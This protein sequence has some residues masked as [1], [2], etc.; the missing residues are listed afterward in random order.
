MSKRKNNKIMLPLLVAWFIFLIMISIFFMFFFG[1]LAKDEKKGDDRETKFSY[2]TNADIEINAT[3]GDYFT[4]LNACD[5]EWLK[6]MVTDPSQ[7]DDMSYYEMLSQLVK[8][9]YNINCYSVDGLNENEVLVF[10]T[11]NLEIDGLDTKPMDIQ[12]FYMIKNADGTYTINNSPSDEINDYIFK[13][14]SDEDIQEIYKSVRDNV[15]KCKED[16]PE[17]AA[18][19]NKLF[20]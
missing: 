2:R 13:V 10:V 11:Y 16:D 1:D 17:F 9:Y 15:E 14:Q 12:T 3:V 7:F 6:T 19:W 4:A 20:E 5:K 8:A 18:L